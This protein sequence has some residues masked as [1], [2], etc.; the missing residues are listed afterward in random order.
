MKHAIRA[1][2]VGHHE[3]LGVHHEAL[4]VYHEAL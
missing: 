4:G 3:A 2:Q 1:T